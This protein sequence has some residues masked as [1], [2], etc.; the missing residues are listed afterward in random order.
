MTI[1]NEDIRL[2]IA[3]ELE[4]SGFN[5]D[6]SFSEEYLQ[7]L[8]DYVLAATGSNIASTNIG[9]IIIA[10]LPKDKGI[11]KT[12]HVIEV[13][14]AIKRYGNPVLHHSLRLTEYVAETVLYTCTA[15]THLTR[16]DDPTEFIKGMTQMVAR[17]DPDGEGKPATDVYMKLAR[18]SKCIEEALAEEDFKLM[19]EEF[20]GTLPASI[21]KAEERIL[22]H[23]LKVKASYITRGKFYTPSYIQGCNT[24]NLIAATASA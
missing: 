15:L 1:H 17:V 2:D 14:E 10:R 19:I 13:R 6:N 8:E 20:F 18:Y 23:L 16:L 3:L 7:R 24:Y 22:M 5:P 11:Q 4:E 9:D 21:T 12:L